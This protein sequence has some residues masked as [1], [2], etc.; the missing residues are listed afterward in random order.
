MLEFIAHGL[1][2][3]PWWGYLAIAAVTIHLTVIGVTL[4]YHRDQAHRALD[5]HPVLRQFFRFWV[6]LTTAMVCSQWVAIHR[7][8]HAF[9]ETEDDP[10]SPQI[11]GL[12]YF[13][14]HGP[15]VYASAYKEQPDIVDKYGRGTPDDRFE[16]FCLRMPRVGVT[17]LAIVEIVLFGAPG[18]AIW[19]AQMLAMPLLASAL[20]NGLGHHSGYRNFEVPDASSNVLSF[21]LIAGGE[22]LHNNHH[23]FPSSARFSIRWFE[24]DVGWMYI[25]ALAAVGL[26]RVRRV[27]PRPKYSS[28]A[29]IDVEA[30]RAVVTNRMHVMRAYRREVL[31]PILREELANRSRGK[32]FRRNRR[33]LMR[34]ARL[35]DE[36]ALTRRQRL[37]ARFPQL[38]VAWRYRESL[39]SIWEERGHS[40][41]RVVE[42][43]R[44]WVANAEQSELTGLARFATRLRTYRLR[45]TA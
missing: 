1:L 17:V 34:D 22:E 3:L 42:R 40:N 16:R 38:S 45:Q 31:L 19:A 37:I 4:Y 9:V 33:L 44:E 28:P 29:R 41:D 13:L 32:Y 7:K 18:L 21:G 35:L 10:H 14:G 23:A 20:V 36:E 15:E 12:R 26:A 24:F 30:L 43:L 25:R 39:R 11:L 2:P 5:L 6:W 27:Y 8:H